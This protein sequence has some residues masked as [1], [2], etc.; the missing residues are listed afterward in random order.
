VHRDPTNPNKAPLIDP[1]KV[2]IKSSNEKETDFCDITNTVSLTGQQE[3]TIDYHIDHRAERDN[4]YVLTKFSGLDALDED[5]LRNIYFTLD[6]KLPDNTWFTLFDTID[7]DIDNLY[8]SDE[9]P[10]YFFR[11]EKEWIYVSIKVSADDFVDTVLP[12]YWK[13]IGVSNVE[14]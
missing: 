6:T 10:I 12:R 9:W 14:S 1:I 3:F 11:E 4:K 13:A 7:K 8:G 2:I 5:C